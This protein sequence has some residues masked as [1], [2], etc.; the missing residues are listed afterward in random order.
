M[1]KIKTILTVCLSLMIVTLFSC[2]EADSEKEWGSARIYMPQATYGNNKYIVPNGGTIAQH[3][4]NYAVSGDR[5][6]IFLGVYRS[7][8]MALEAYSVKINWSNPSQAGYTCLPEGVFTLPEQVSVISGNREKTF[9]LSVDLNFLRD[10]K[11]TNYSLAVSLSDPTNYS[12]N[13][14]V[15][16]TFVLI[17]TTL[18]LE[19]IDKSE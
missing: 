4:L 6:N 1:N 3:N 16:T 2:G 17:N 9:Y 7:G 12:L 14:D 8:L 5:V 15:S 19:K 18:L 13:T 10:N 11:G